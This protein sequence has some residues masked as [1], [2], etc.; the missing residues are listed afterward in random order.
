MSSPETVDVAKGQGAAI[1]IMARVG[2]EDGHGA[3][4]LNGWGSRS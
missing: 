2:T 1:T 3:A 4:A